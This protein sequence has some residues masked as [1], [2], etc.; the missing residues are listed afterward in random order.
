MG[1]AVSEFIGRLESY[2]RNARAAT[3][4]FFKAVMGTQGCSVGSVPLWRWRK[5]A[6]LLSCFLAG[7]CYLRCQFHFFSTAGCRMGGGPTSLFSA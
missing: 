1:T 7:G 4:L 3:V 6:T 2:E 5:G